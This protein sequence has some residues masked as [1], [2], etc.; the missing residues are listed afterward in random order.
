MNLPFIATREIAARPGAVMRR[1]HREGALVITDHGQ[2][3]A[4]VLPVD[5]TTFLDT[6]VDVLAAQALSQVRMRAASGGTS[7][8]T[9]AQILKLVRT[10]RKARARRAVA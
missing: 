1:L 5:G 2:P 6:A 8:M 10:T 3:R 9:P 7:K 4:L